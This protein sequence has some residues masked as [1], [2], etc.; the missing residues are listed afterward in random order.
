ML[1]Y[2]LVIFSVAGF[3]LVFAF[4]GQLAKYFTDNTKPSLRTTFYLTIEYGLKNFLLAVIH[5]LLRSS[6][7]YGIQFAALSAVE[8]VCLA[9][10]IQFLWSV[11]LCEFRYKVWLMIIFGTL[12]IM[13]LGVLYIQQRSLNDQAVLSVLEQVISVIIFLYLA[14][15]LLGLLVSVV[16]VILQAFKFMYKC[17]VKSEKAM[18]SVKKNAGKVDVKKSKTAL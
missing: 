4:L 15:I 16:I 7:L 11:K 17:V 2:F 10:N 14:F 18:P 12:R 1:L 9:N 5:A 6:D 13:L 3:F 8:I